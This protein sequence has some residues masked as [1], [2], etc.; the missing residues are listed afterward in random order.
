M[1]TLSFF[2]YTLTTLFQDDNV[3][4]TDSLMYGFL[5][6]QLYRLRLKTVTYLQFV[7][8]KFVFNIVPPLFKGRDISDLWESLALDT[9]TSRILSL[10]TRHW[11]GRQSVT[12]I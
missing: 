5:N 6:H 1:R 8:I 2:S 12:I 3:G 10:Y 4:R 9:F 11:A 7:K